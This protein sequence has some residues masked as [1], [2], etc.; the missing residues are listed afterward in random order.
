[1]K[2]SMII[3]LLSLFLVVSCGSDDKDNVIVPSTTDTIY[4]DSYN[5][6]I[7]GFTGGSLGIGFSGGLN[8]PS[9]SEYKLAVQNGQ[10]ST[11]ASSTGAYYIF[12]T[13]KTTS[14]SSNWWSFGLESSQNEN[15]G[16]E[17]REVY[18]DGSFS[19]PYCIT[20]NQSCTDF[21]IVT[22]AIVSLLDTATHYYPISSTRFQVLTSDQTIYEFDFSRDVMANP[23]MMRKL[24]GSY[25][26]YLQNIY[27]RF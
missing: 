24:D 6:P 3:G 9:F 15:L 7:N 20:V 16:T 23:V 2:T 19:H 25:G 11:L 5:A 12:Q 14:T 4:P 21:G 13:F 10:F 22:S 17:T 18:S 26:Y 8:Y 1:M 27:T